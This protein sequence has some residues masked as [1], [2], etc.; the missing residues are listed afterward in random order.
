MSN[1]GAP[2]K[3]ENRPTTITGL[4]QSFPPPH[5]YFLLQGIVFVVDAA[6]AS[7]LEEAAAALEMVTQHEET[8]VGSGHH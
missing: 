7:H 1:R 2:G 5:K 8:Q 6:D 3:Q 4:Q